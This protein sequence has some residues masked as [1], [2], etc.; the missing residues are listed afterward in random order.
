MN[1]LKNWIK[2]KTAAPD[3]IVK[4]IN[5]ADEINKYLESENFEKEL[6]EQVQ[7][8]I[9]DNISSVVY[10]SFRDG[11]DYIQKEKEATAFRK[12][13]TDKMFEILNDDKEMQGFMY[14]VFR[15][16]F[17]EQFHSYVE[18]LNKKDR[19]NY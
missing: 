10:Q 9:R 3:E 6:Q 2:F 13:V 16:E 14:D 12:R 18:K 15:D 8:A 7:I 4:V 1:L 19:Y 17:K 5:T 11:S